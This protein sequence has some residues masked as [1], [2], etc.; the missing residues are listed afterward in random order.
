M[1]VR[2]EQQAVPQEVQHPREDL[3]VVAVAPRDRCRRGPCRC[4]NGAGVSQEAPFLCALT[5]SR[6]TVQRCLAPQVPRR[7]AHATRQ[8]QLHDLATAPPR[9]AAGA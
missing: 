3:A 1:V 7:R 9:V 8:E 5:E 6:T 2:R 4:A